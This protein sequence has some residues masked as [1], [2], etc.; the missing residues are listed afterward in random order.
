M[1]A[2]HHMEAGLA[3]TMIALITRLK[4]RIAKIIGRQWTL[5]RRPEVRDDDTIA[6]HTEDGSN[7]CANG[8]LLP[9]DKSKC[10]FFCL[11]VPNVEPETPV[12]SVFLSVKRRCG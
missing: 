6:V 10:H 3:P 5:I 8:K 4:S 2:E 1:V 7:D 9:L 11:S 12:F